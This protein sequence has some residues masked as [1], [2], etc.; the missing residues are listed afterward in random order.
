MRTVSTSTAL[1]FVVV[2][3][4]FC[5]SVVST[6]AATVTDAW[7]PSASRCLTCLRALLSTAGLVY[8]I[9]LAVVH[10]AKRL[11]AREVATFA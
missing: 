7:A 5:T 11:A 9:A 3:I 2:C 8:F 10:R 4:V 6:Q 1:F